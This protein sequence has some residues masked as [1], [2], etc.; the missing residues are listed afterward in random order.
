MNSKRKTIELILFFVTIILFAL[1]CSNS[2]QN[3][4]VLLQ[5]NENEVQFRVDS[6]E[7][8]PEL[9]I[10]IMLTLS[11]YSSKKVILFFDTLSTSP[12][13][14]SM[15]VKNLYMVVPSDTFNV[16]INTRQRYLVFKEHC[17][18]S[19]FCYGLRGHDNG[20]LYSFEQIDSVVSQGKMIYEFDGKIPQKVSQED[21][22]SIADTFLVPYKLEAPMFKAARGKL[23][24][25][26]VWI[27][28][29]L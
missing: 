13:D 11:N 19:F 6:V 5:A 20:E 29:H 26:Y 9:G 27:E 14:Y 4:I 24:S 8:W 28:R 18:T 10:P 12:R 25:R 17:V 21:L 16:K 7:Q 22:L 2:K 23:S 1:S 3:A 15:K